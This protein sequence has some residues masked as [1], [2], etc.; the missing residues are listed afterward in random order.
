MTVYVDQGADAPLKVSIVIPSYNQVRYLDAAIRSVVE[1]NL[2]RLE[3]IVMDGGSTDGSVDVIR[4]YEPQLASWRSGADGGQANAIK[5][6]FGLATGHIIGWLNSDDVLAP[7]ALKRLA[8]A[9]D[10]V[11]TPDGVFYGG[12]EVI[13][14]HGEVQELLPGIPAVP[15]IARAIGPALAQPGTFFGRAAYHRVGGVDPSLKYAMD[16]DL[17]MRFV[18]ADVR[19]VCL[20]GVQGGFR[21]HRE[22]KGRSLEWLKSCAEEENLI[23]RRYMMAPDRSMR[24]LFAR[25]MHRV[26]RLTRGRLAETLAYRILKRHR[27]R[28]FA[29]DYST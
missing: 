21:S 16:L 24:R 3:I 11:G 9:V 5:T 23:R 15:W 19:F 26:L 28:A 17:W 20:S 25:Q 7:G 18:R 8:R 13:D 2:P 27:L 6:G 10:Q 29:V 22:Q 4:K 14:T 12:C 1:Q